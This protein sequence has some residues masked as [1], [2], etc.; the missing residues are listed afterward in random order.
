[1]YTYIYLCTY[2][3]TWLCTMICKYI[4]I[5]TYIN[6][7]TRERGGEKWKQA[8]YMSYMSAYVYMYIYV[9]T[10]TYPCKGNMIYLLANAC[11]SFCY[12]IASLPSSRHVCRIFF[13]SFFLFSFYHFFL[14]FFQSFEFVWIVKLIINIHVL[15]PQASTPFG[16]KQSRLER[17]RSCKRS[18]FL[19]GIDNRGKVRFSVFS[20]LN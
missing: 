9:Y 3:Y 12:S 1:M 16:K 10:C 7:C 6:T 11:R 14:P 18:I 13:F 19:R 8:T 5:H 20:F 4:D 2:M 17:A 15:Q